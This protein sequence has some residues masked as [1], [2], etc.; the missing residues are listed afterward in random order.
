MAQIRL[1]FAALKTGLRNAAML[2]EAEEEEKKAPLSKDNEALDEVLSKSIVPGAKGVLSLLYKLY[3]KKYIDESIGGQDPKNVKDLENAIDNCQNMF[4]KACNLYVGDSSDKKKVREVGKEL[5]I[6]QEIIKTAYVTAAKKKTLAAV[7]K[8]EA[9]R[10][11]KSVMSDDEEAIIA[12]VDPSRREETIRAWETFKFEYEEATTQAAQLYTV[13]NQAYSVEV[14]KRRAE[15]KQKF[16]KANINPAVARRL[17]ELHE[18]QSMDPESWESWKDKGAGTKRKSSSGPLINPSY[19]GKDI[20][21]PYDTSKRPM[22][23]I[24]GVELRRYSPDAYENW[25]KLAQLNPDMRDAVC[26]KVHAGH[27]VRPGDPGTFVLVPSNPAVPSLFWTPLPEKQVFDKETK[28]VVVIPASPPEWRTMSEKLSDTQKKKIGWVDSLEKDA[29]DRTK[30]DTPVEDTSFAQPNVRFKEKGST[31]GSLGSQQLSWNEDDPV[32]DEVSAAPQGAVSG[33]AAPIAPGA[34]VTRPSALART[35]LDIAKQA[36]KAPTPHWKSMDLA[37]LIKAYKFAEN[38]VLVNPSAEYKQA[39]NDII[40]AWDEREDGI[41]PE[42][43]RYGDK[44]TTKSVKMYFS[45]RDPRFI[46]P[47]S[48]KELSRRSTDPRY[49]EFIG[50]PLPI[51][52]ARNVASSALIPEPDPFIEPG[53]ELD[54]PRVAKRRLDRKNLARRIIRVPEEPREPVSIKGLETPPWRPS[55]ATPLE[56][57]IPPELK[58]RELRKMGTQALKGAET[59]KPIHTTPAAVRRYRANRIA[60][61]EAEIARK[62][63]EYWKDDKTAEKAAIHAQR[64]QEAILRRAAEAE[65]KRLRAAELAAEIDAATRA[66]A[67]IKIQQ[68]LDKLNKQEEERPANRYWD[69]KTKTWRKL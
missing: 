68:H 42:P 47:P 7:E 13:G 41:P 52:V 2:L 8:K 6:F 67:D 35:H 19:K 43:I 63:R 34:V 17:L 69:S 50:P 11:E 45:E 24:S 62:S 32:Y 57:D 59:V 30:F 4:E 27:W 40:E 25:K 31:G 58:S 66:E 29:R 36:K 51:P 33:A 14:L 26:A 1:T 12:K 65:A 22:V 53:E 18:E 38:A 16:L 54:D 55:R 10:T 44:P 64:E 20:Q 5:E 49:D 21:R 48:E 28:K 3:T 46:G 56:G 61:A 15:A 9:K 37:E 60:D 23:E 39:L